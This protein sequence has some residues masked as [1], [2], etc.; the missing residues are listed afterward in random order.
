MF[1]RSIKAW[2][3]ERAI[4]VDLRGRISQRK[5]LGLGWGGIT[6]GAWAKVKMNIVGAQPRGS[7]Y[8]NTVRSTPIQYILEGRLG[9]R[10][11]E[12][13]RLAQRS[14]Q[15][16]SQYVIWQRPCFKITWK[17]HAG[18]Q[19]CLGDQKG[20]GNQ[21]PRIGISKP[22]LA[23]LGCSLATVGASVAQ[24]QLMRGNVFGLELHQRESGS[25]QRG[26]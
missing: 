23:I 11:S 17:Q 7:P 12:K 6:G 9:N 13:V 8:W 19:L 15:F 16:W 5:R 10:P 24:K 20:K 25:D 2:G 21:P 22:S 3:R 14:H 18:G 4:Q 1:W 26:T